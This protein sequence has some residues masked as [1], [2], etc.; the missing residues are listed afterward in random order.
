M[1]SNDNSEDSKGGEPV[2]LWLSRRELIFLHNTLGEAFEVAQDDK[3]LKARTGEAYESAKKI[4]DKLDAICEDREQWR[5]ATLVGKPEMKRV[6][7]FV[8]VQE[9]RFLCKAAEVTLAAVE[10]WELDTRTGATPEV[11]RALLNRMRVTLEGARER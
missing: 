3:E 4:I 1:I 7:V 11:A 5:S 6:R 2:S 9:L 8:S 10:D